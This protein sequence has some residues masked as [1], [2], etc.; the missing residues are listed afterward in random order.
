MPCRNPS[1]RPRRSASAPRY[2]VQS[3]AA[4]Q[5][6]A[7]DADN[8]GSTV[9]LDDDESRARPPHH[10][11]RGIGWSELLMIPSASSNRDCAEGSPTR[12]ERAQPGAR[13]T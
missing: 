5:R 1:L 7:G 11:E 10:G 3:S 9:A 6:R 2:P 12:N 13:T 8:A 4:L